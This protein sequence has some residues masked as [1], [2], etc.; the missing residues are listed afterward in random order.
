VLSIAIIRGVDLNPFELCSFEP[1]LRTHRLVAF[2]ARRTWAPLDGTRVDIQRLPSPAEAPLFLPAACQRV[3]RAALHRLL[4][5]ARNALLG[6]P[7]AVRGFDVLHPAE[8]HNFYSYQAAGVKKRTGARLVV[9]CWENLPH[10]FERHPLTRAIKRAV[11]HAA[12]AFIAVSESAR[13]ALLAEGVSSDRIAVSAPGVDVSAFHPTGPAVSRTALGLPADRPVVLYVG[14]LVRDKGVHDIVDAAAR[15]SRTEAVWLLV[16]AGRERA[17]LE[18]RAARA[19]LDGDLRILGPRRHDE[20]PPLYR[21]A[22][23]FVLP[24]R[25]A[26]HWQEQFGLVLIEA[27]ASGLPVIATDTGAI[28]EVI[29]PAGMIIPPGDP[30]QLASAVERLLGDP[31]ERR[32]LGRLARARAEENFSHHLAA[33]RL[34]AIYKRVAA[35]LPPRADP[36]HDEA[37]TGALTSSGPA[38][39]RT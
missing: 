16:G 13:Q 39:G 37:A 38:R 35:G 5:G 32:R 22:D 19:G 8:T 28:P 10:N 15:A 36:H 14:R 25:P 21:L 20:L 6:L 9:T 29:G 18:A 11:R 17:A 24:S 33:A 31:A 23:I 3:S 2:A 12:D 27:M 30:D 4:G 1:L 7:D 34:A 26:P